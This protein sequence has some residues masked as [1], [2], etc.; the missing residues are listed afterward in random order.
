MRVGFRSIGLNSI[1]YS[2]FV[3][4]FIML[5]FLSFR[6]G[7]VILMLSKLSSNSSRPT[8]VRSRVLYAFLVSILPIPVIGYPWAAIGVIFYALIGIVVVRVWI[9]GIC[10]RPSGLDSKKSFII[11]DEA[12]F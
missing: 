7:S 11:G 3:Y 9:S 10:E 8:G 12:V 4:A 5:R 6:V 1:S 2:S